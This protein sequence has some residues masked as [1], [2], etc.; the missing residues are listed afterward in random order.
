[1]GKQVLSQDTLRYLF[2][3]IISDPTRGVLGSEARI[4]C[5]MLAFCQLNAS[6]KTLSF[7]P[8]HSLETAATNMLRVSGWLG[9]Y[10]RDRMEVDACVAGWRRRSKRLSFVHLF[11]VCVISSAR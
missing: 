5:F 1:M 4:K 8:N 6:R 3:N 9:R 11:V 10:M 7:E 2:T